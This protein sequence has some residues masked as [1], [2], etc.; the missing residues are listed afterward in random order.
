MFFKRKTQTVTETTT[1]FRTS[2]QKLDEEYKQNKE[3]LLGNFQNKLKNL[4]EIKLQDISTLKNTLTETKTKITEN[5]HDV[6]NIRKELNTCNEELD[7]TTT[8]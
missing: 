7:P 1:I 8:N 6:E 5:E 3:T 4:L 2:M